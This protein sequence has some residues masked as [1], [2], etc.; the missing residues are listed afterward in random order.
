MLQMMKIQD[1]PQNNIV[2]CLRK[3]EAE[4]IYFS[5]ARDILIEQFKRL[6]QSQ[7]NQKDDIETFEINLQKAK[8]EQKFKDF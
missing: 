1:D 2:S 4:L 8:T 5:E 3:I 6:P 7:K